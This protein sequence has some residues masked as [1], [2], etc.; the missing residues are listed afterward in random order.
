MSGDFSYYGNCFGKQSATSY[1][2]QSCDHAL[3]LQDMA[4]MVVCCSLLSPL[5]SC[6]MAFVSCLPFR[7]CDGWR[8]THISKMLNKIKKYFYSFHNAIT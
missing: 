3:L 6:Q 2:F 5:G 7:S 8:N 4:I 1:I